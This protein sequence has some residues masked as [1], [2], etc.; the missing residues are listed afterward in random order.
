MQHRQTLARYLTAA[1]GKLE[2]TQKQVGEL[3]GVDASQV[4]R[5]ERADQLPG[6]Q[7]LSALADALHLDIVELRALFMEAQQEELVSAR[8]ERDSARHERDL[9]LTAMRSFVDKYG[10]FHGAYEEINLRVRRIDEQLEARIAAAVLEAL[11][12]TQADAG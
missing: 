1:R 6:A 9:L 3:L 7:R 2:L 11:R 10:E 12:Q 4:S 8:Q 5:W